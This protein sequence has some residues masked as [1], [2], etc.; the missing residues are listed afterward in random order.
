MRLA[1]LTIFLWACGAP[2][3]STSEPGEASG[4]ATDAGPL[5]TSESSVET[6]ATDSSSAAP[7]DAGGLSGPDASSSG[8][9]G[10]VDAPVTADAAPVDARSCP[11][12]GCA[13]VTISQGSGCGAGGFVY[14]QYCQAHN[15][16]QCC[17]WPEPTCAP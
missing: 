10:A 9:D 13:C 4:L 5:T 1:C 8:S 11:D 15:L 12:A 6:S 17:N 7:P 14:M 16:L 3:T 2:F